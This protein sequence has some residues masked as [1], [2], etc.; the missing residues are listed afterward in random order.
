MDAKDFD[1][2]KSGDNGQRSEVL[3]IFVE[4]VIFIYLVKTKFN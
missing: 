4:K 1:I 3:R 2:I